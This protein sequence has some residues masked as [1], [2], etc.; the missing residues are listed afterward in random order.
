MLCERPLPLYSNRCI[1]CNTEIDSD[2][3]F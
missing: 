3:V 1:Y 2:R